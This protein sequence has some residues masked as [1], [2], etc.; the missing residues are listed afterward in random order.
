MNPHE[1]RFVPV[2]VSVVKL[3][4]V[5]KGRPCDEEVV[6]IIQERKKSDNKEKSEWPCGP[7][8]GPS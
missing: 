2:I 4:V 7:C 8:G 3:F 5:V 1:N 6:G